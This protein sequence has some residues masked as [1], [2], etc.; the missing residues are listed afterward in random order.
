MV[1]ERTRF[2]SR[3][4]EANGEWITR[5]VWGRFPKSLLPGPVCLVAKGSYC[6]HCDGERQWPGSVEA[7]AT[8]TSVSTTTYGTGELI[9]G[10]N[11]AGR[12]THLAG[13][14]R[15]RY[16]GWRSG[17]RH[18][19][20]LAISG[21]T[22]GD[23]SALAAV[24]LERIAP[25]RNIRDELQIPAQ[26]KFFA[27]WTIH[28]A[29]SMA[30]PAFSVPQKGAAPAMVDRLDAGLQHLGRLSEGATGQGYRKC[31]RRRGG[32]GLAGAHWRLWMHGS[33]RALR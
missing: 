11:R 12:E 26:W 17:L 8:D 20:R 27:T 16:R 15:Q 3:R 28:S 4:W 2:F 10:R 13:G 19:P 14:R 25:D 22:R 31:S 6:G 18:G 24:E 7:R 5:P 21:C 32:R 9:P 23:L 30:P 33:R 1:T 29:A